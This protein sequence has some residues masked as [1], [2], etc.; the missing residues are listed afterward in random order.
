M[1]KRHIYILVEASLHF[2]C[3]TH[4]KTAKLFQTYSWLKY[5]K[6]QLLGY[7][8][9]YDGLL[10]PNNGLENNTPPAPYKIKVKCSFAESNVA[11]EV[12]NI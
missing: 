4:L 5:A 6:N 10:L 9:T 2:A 12:C 7:K 1:E 11:W 3:A 8:L